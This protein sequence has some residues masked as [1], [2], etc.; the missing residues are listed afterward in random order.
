[1]STDPL[2][3]VARLGVLKYLSDRLNTARKEDLGPQA[4]A[5]FPVGSRLPVMIGGEHAG[6]LSIPQPR[7]TASVTNEARFLAWAKELFPTEVVKVEQVRSSFQA[8]VLQSVKDRGGWVDKATGELV[9]V[10][11]VEVK[12]GDPYTKV[13][14]TEGM[15][16]IIGRAWLAG[17][18]DL[19]EMLALP[20][21]P[22]DG[23]PGVAA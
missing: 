18:L 3:L 1:M 8:N 15:G 9:D 5:A 10:P 17:E 13:D 21:A 4:V 22:E 6:W 19:R 11:G 7:R 16:D 12:D 20:A 2:A 23:A 14:A